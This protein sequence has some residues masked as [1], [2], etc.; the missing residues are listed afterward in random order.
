M[1]KR[2]IKHHERKDTRDSIS[3]NQLESQVEKRG[4]LV[5]TSRGPVKNKETKRESRTGRKTKEPKA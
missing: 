4:N 2:E 5:E 1:K 3:A